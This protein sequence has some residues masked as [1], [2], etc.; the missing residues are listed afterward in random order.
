MSFPRKYTRQY[1]YVSYQNANPN[2]PLPATKINA[3]LNA[4]AQSTSE[5]VDFIKGIARADGKIA[6]GAVGFDQLSPALQS[7]GIAPADAWAASTEYAA[8]NSVIT[9]GALYRCLVKHTSTVFA[10]DLA[11]GYWLF[12]ADVATGPQGPQG[13]QGIQ[14]PEGP[15]GVQ[16]IQGPQG[17]QGIQGPQGD[18]GPQGNQGIQG[19][20]G[21]NPGFTTRAAAVAATIAGSLS[22]ISTSGYAAANDGGGGTYMRLAS[23]PGVVRNWHFQSADGAYWQ[24]RTD[25]VLPKQVGAALDGTTDDTTAL[26]AWVDYSASFGAVAKDQAGTA[27]VPTG[28]ISL[29]SNTNVNGGN[30]LTLKRTSNVVAALMQGTSVSNVSVR[31]LNF[32]TTA[33]FS[34]TSSNTIGNTAQSYTVPA[35]LNLV[36]GNFVQ[37]TAADAPTN[38]MIAQ[39]TAYSGTTLSVTAT[40]SVGAGSYVSWRLDVYPL[41]GALADSNHALRFRTCTNVT[42]ENNVVNGRFYN[43]IDFRNTNGV[44]VRHNSVTGHVNRG[45]AAQ[46][47]TFAMSDVKITHNSVDGNSFAQYGIVTD[48]TSSGSL[49]QMLIHSNTVGGTLFQGIS[50]GGGVSNSSVNDN[51]VSVASTAAS[52]I[53]LDKADGLVP[54][55][56]VISGNATNGGAAGINITDALYAVISGNSMV[57]GVNG[58]LITGTSAVSAAYISV[59]GNK[60]TGASSHG[61]NFQ[62]SVANAVFGISLSGNLAITNGGWGFNS[63]ANVGSIVEVGNISSANTLGAYGITG[64]TAPTNGNI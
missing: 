60:V 42:V 36:I 46:S 64:A 2:R 54:Q 1:D 24:L 50:M 34:S 13:I 41:N 33:G 55:N 35:G 43:G 27:V 10:T 18:Q 40:T 32:D 57:G 8:G 14:G 21:P 30:L 9:A 7:A 29:A 45:I 52:C 4:A 28:V 63:N 49:A 38:Y 15:Q 44:Y 53:L 22:L 5:I 20:V 62:G 16:G 48:A 3:D 12:V 23:A 17:D 11:A 51:T 25:A 56:N 47:F 6:N 59:T 31:G 39:I 58:L 19:P 37:I 61:Y 26:Q